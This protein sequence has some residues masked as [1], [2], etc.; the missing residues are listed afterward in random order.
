MMDRRRFLLTS[1]AGAIAAPRAV[2]AQPAHIPR[3]GVLSGEFPNDSPCVDRLRRALSNLGFVEGRTHILELR[4]RTVKWM[5][6]GIRVTSGPLGMTKRAPGRSS[7]I[8]VSAVST[9]SGLR[10]SINISDRPNFR[11]SASSFSWIGRGTTVGSQ[12]SATRVRFG[13]ASFSSSKYFPE[14][15]APRLSP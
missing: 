12:S 4:C 14:R 15:R 6:C 7:A 13:T 5:R 8:L 1:L 11:A 2:E 3:I 9:S 10:G